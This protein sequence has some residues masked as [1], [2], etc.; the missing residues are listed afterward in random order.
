MSKK[1]IWISVIIVFIVA[2]RIALPFIIESYVN[3]T[4]DNLEGYTGSVQDIDLNLYRGAYVID[5]FDIR[6][7]GD[8]IPVPFVSVA[9]TDISLHWNAL[10]NGALVGEVIL[11]HPKINFANDKGNSKQDGS[12]ADWTKTLNELI[13]V[14][15]NRFEVI[16]G[17]ISYKDFST[18]PQIDVFVE[19]LN[20]LAT[21]L[22]NIKSKNDTLPSTLEA[23][24]TSIGG[25]HLDVTAGMNAMKEVPDLD[26][27]LEFENVQ[28]PALNDFVRAYTN[29]DVEKG[30]FNLYTEIVIKDAQLTGYVKPVL[31]DL[32]IVAWNESEGNFIQKSWEALVGAVTE[33]FENQAKDQLATRVPLEGN[34][35]DPDVGVW[36]TVWNV[37][38][39]AFVNAFSK[40]V[41]HT[42]EFEENN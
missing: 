27:N 3:K 36:P 25:G 28:M 38:K 33:L 40:Q 31:E 26:L 17:K 37:F 12:G 7:T 1:W 18:S 41:D 15:I 32:K 2:V 14:K 29:T 16:N 22:T 35:N 30:V 39:N 9:K 8:S 10:L 13:P 6:K 20:L 23:S 21:N 5:S 11:K 24:G 19:D 42:L 34:L 4:L